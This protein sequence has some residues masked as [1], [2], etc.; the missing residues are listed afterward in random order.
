MDVLVEV[1]D[2]AEL[3]TALELNTSL[4]GINNRN[5]R[6]FE[7]SLQNPLDLLPA[8][9]QGKTV[10]TESGIV[11]PDD[12]TQMRDP[13]VNALLVGEAYMRAHERGAGLQVIF[14]NS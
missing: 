12:V 14:L 7:T 13:D 2:R 1:H 10:I 6:T 8:V 11:T 5:M 3:D 4:I 9:P